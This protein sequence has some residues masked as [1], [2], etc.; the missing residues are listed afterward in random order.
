MIFALR[1]YFSNGTVNDVSYYESETQAMKHRDDLRARLRHQPTEIIRAEVVRIDVVSKPIEEL[2]FPEE[3][4]KLVD[5]CTALQL[6]MAH[7]PD[8]VPLFHGP[9]ET[10]EDEYLRLMS[11]LAEVLDDE[12]FDDEA[13]KPYLTGRQTEWLRANEGK[14]RQHLQGKIV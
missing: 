11:H 3:V 1:L 12:D 13:F 7:L 6:K 5:R 14:I 2:R 4:G 8:G 9:Q 10:A